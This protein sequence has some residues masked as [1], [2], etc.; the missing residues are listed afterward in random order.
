M[1]VNF[2]Y[3]CQ[4]AEY[5]SQVKSYFGPNGPP[6]HWETSSGGREVEPSSNV[7]KEDE[8]KEGD[9]YGGEEPSSSSLS[10]PKLSD[11]LPGA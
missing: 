4:I 5:V 9:K 3:V 8:S 1:L 10:R 2:S 6:E 7:S 11:Y